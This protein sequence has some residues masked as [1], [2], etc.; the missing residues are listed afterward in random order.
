MSKQCY[1]CQNFSAY[2]CSIC[3]ERAKN[4]YLP[5][6]LKK[7]SIGEH[8]K[9]VEYG[10]IK[11]KKAWEMLPM[12]YKLLFAAIVA[13]NPNDVTKLATSLVRGGWQ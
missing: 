2:G 4:G 5:H 13:E 6:H 9:N 10:N 1:F 11:T 8:L 12:G 7:H 3:I